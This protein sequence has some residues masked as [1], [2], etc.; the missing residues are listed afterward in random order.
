[1]RNA[2]E[3][4]IQRTAMKHSERLPSLRALLR[5]FLSQL[6][7]SQVTADEV[8]SA[9]CKQCGISAVED[10]EVTAGGTTG[11][12]ISAFVTLPSDTPDPDVVVRAAGESLRK[13]L[14]ANEVLL[15]YI[16][17]TGGRRGILISE[18]Q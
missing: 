10:V 3:A 5:A 18:V 14:Q 16:G 13:E 9:L 17:L 12:R 15:I 1:M 11:V 2:L 4:R 8:K 7:S 6:Y